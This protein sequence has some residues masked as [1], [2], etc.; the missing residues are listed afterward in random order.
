MQIMLKFCVPEDNIYP[1][2][3][4]FLRH[5]AGISLTQWRKIKRDG[6]ILI[7]DHSASASV[8]LMPGDIVA[9]DRVCHC[10]I[11]PAPYPLRVCYEDD[12]LL[13]VDKPSGMLVHP[14]VQHEAVTLANAVSFYYQS[15]GLRCGFHPVHRLDRNTSGLVLIAKDPHIQHLFNR[16]HIKILDRTYWGVAAGIIAPPDGMIDA[17]IGR[18]PDSIIERMVCP[19]GQCAVTMYK[20]LRTFS[21]AS[22]IELTLRT[23]RTHQIRVHLSSIGHPLLGDDLYGGSTNHIGRQALHA[24][25]LVF[26]H[27]MTNNKIVVISPL[28]DDIV[29]LLQHLAAGDDQ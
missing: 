1:A 15:E 3:R 13:V 8:K 11:V 23:G 26:P 14:T 18:K 6:T 10:D 22:L 12:Y 20:L 24:T 9:I 5:S 7:N 27:P 2:V 29:A 28:P 17:R 25:K 4:D 19:D 21:E 16:N